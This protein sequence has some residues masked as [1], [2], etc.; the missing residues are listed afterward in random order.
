MSGN[1]RRNLGNFEGLPCY[2]PEYQ[3]KEEK[4]IRANWPSKGLR[5]GNPSLTFFSLLV[6]DS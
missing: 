4:G 6:L 3:R 1:E 5:I 2:K